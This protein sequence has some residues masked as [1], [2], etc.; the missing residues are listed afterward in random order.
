M[1]TLAKLCIFSAVIAVIVGI[2]FKCAGLNINHF[3]PVYP[4]QPRSF[5]NFADSMLLLSISFL[6]L[7]KREDD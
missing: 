1:R 4:V 2:V 6:L 5:L 3:F 7:G